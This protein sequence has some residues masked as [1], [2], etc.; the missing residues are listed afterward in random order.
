MIGP[1]TRR[2]RAHRSTGRDTATTYPGTYLNPV[3]MRRAYDADGNVATRSGPFTSGDALTRDA[4]GRLVSG[5][6]G[7]IAGNGPAGIRL[8]YGA[9]GAVVY[10]ENLTQGATF[11]EDSVDALGNRLWQR[12]YG[13]NDEYIDRHR[14]LFLDD[15]TGRLDSIKLVPPHPVGWPVDRPDTNYL[16]NRAHIAL[17]DEAGNSHQTY[18]WPN[19]YRAEG[20]VWDVQLDEAVSYFDAADRLRIFNR[21]TGLGPVSDRGGLY[22]EYR[23]DA[24]GRRVLV[25]SRCTASAPT[26]SNCRGSVERTVWD[27]AQVLYELRAP[28]HDSAGAWDLENDTY[29]GTNPSGYDLM[30]G[31]VGYVHAG[32]IDAPLAVYRMGM[33]GQPAAVGVAPHANFQGDFEIGSLIGGSYPG[34]STRGC[35]GYYGCPLINWPGGNTTIDGELPNPNPIQTWFGSLLSQRTDGSGLQ[36][37]RNRYYDAR[38]GRFTQSDPIGLAGGLNLY[39][40]ASG[41][42]VNFS[43]PFGLCTP[44][45]WCHAQE[46]AEHW[47]GVAAGS[48]G[49]ARAG[50][51]LMGGLATLVSD[52]KRAALTGL[53]LATAGLASGA[54]AGGGAA[55]AA[56]ATVAAEGPGALGTIAGFTRHGINQVV[57][58]GVR[59]ADILQA[60]RNSDAVRLVDEAGRVSFRYVGDK[61]TVVLN[62][63]GKVITAW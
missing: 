26:D 40:F 30:L 6:I 25:R 39:G 9:L 51:N 48:T 43:D 60:V 15:Y 19:P 55:V 33:A 46:A 18:G 53:T 24:L 20:G 7:D 37:L 45:P 56:D 14:R 49:V 2:A 35:Q 44:W 23:Y 59:P 41:D 50:A 57:T 36:Y 54:A 62:T 8:F 42:P 1:P 12:A 52:G 32:G 4:Q 10:T 29:Y 16:I 3:V 13:M 5:A 11:E 31:R 47:A 38:T 28:G 21:H 61:A 34:Q 22:E 17:Y 27:G 63:A 58:R